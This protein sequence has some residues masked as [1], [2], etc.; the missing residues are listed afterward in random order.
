MFSK[1]VHA[2]HRLT[3]TLIVRGMARPMVLVIREFAFSWHESCGR[4]VATRLAKGATSFVAVLEL[5]SGNGGSNIG[6][7]HT[8]CL[9]Q[10]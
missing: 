9:M 2:R 6:R 10:I 8:S 4:R 1:S 7:S 3:K 5:R